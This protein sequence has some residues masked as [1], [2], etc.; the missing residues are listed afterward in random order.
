MLTP[1]HEPLVVYVGGTFERTIELWEDAAHTKHFNLT[2]YT[3]ELKIEGV[4]TLTSGSGLT[5]TVAEGK[6]E[7]TMTPAQTAE[8]QAGTN[9]H[10]FLSI[11]KTG[12]TWFPLDG[13]MEYKLP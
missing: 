10:Y 3:V 13:T 4:L 6:I 8:V 11:T 7:I 5:V 2:G 9:A 1:A 12:V